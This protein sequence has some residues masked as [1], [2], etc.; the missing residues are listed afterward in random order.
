[1]HGP[2]AWRMASRKTEQKSKPLQAPPRETVHT[3]FVGVSGDGHT[4]KWRRKAEARRLGKMMRFA[5]LNKQDSEPSSLATATGKSSV[6]TR[7]AQVG[8][9]A[10]YEPDTCKAWNEVPMNGRSFSC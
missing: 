7:E 1:M 8:Y 3:P 2:W 6:P 10:W 9:H 4:K 5:A